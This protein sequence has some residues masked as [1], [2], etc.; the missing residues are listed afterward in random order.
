MYFN[1]HFKL[2]VRVQ[3]VVHMSHN[4]FYLRSLE[5]ASVYVPK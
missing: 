5:A 2:E 3:Y 1:Y 4:K